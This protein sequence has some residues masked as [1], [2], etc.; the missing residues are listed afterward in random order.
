MTVFGGAGGRAN[1]G[2]MQVDGLNTGAA[3]N[4]GGVSTYVADISNAAEVVT[5]TSGGM[6]E[7]EVGGPSLSIVPKSGGNTV[8]GQIYLSGVPQRHG[9]QQLHAGLK[10]AGLATPGQL[11]K[12][13]DDTG[14]VGGPIKKDRL[15]YYGTYRDE[16]QH[17]SIPGIYPNLNAGD[18]TKCD[19]RCPTRP[20]RRG[21]RELPARQHPP[22]VAGD[23]A[24]QVQLP[25]GRAVAVQRRRVRHERRRLPHA[26]AIR[27]V[28]RLARTRRSDGDVV[29]RDRRVPAHDGPEPPGHVVV[30]GDQPAAARSRRRDRIARR[31]VRSRAR[32]IRR[33][34]SR[35]SPSS[36]ARNGAR[37]RISTYRSAELG[38]GL[39]QPEH[40][41][42]LGV[43]RH[44]RPQPEVRVRRR[45]P[46]RRHREPRQRP[47]PGVHVQRRPAPSL[48]ES[49]RV[50]TQK[51]RVENH[52]ALRRRTSGRTDG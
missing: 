14:G 13:W 33:A 15:W 23:A 19:V 47:Q 46:R 41:A 30:A 6:G 35:A 37:R 17:R 29:A 43:V 22:D 9:R 36:T 34:A 26:A 1:E 52:R 2:R 32:A 12:Q 51:D 5:T 39:R 40:V 48:T 16:G 25:L 28:R 4:G 50:F 18:P 44:R 38:A 45:L 8:K 11:L 24:Q 21:R 3:L 20:S 49:L 10:V 31:G 7:A 27:R 42:R